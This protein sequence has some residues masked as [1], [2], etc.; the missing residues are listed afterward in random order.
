MF[1]SEHSIFSDV[2]NCLLISAILLGYAVHPLW[3]VYVTAIRIVLE[4][5]QSASVAFRSIFDL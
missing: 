3:A 4:R 5:R 1:D 2:R